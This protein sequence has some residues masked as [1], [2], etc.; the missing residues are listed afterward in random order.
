M[1]NTFYHAITRSFFGKKEMSNDSKTWIYK[2]V[3]KLILTY[4]SETVVLLGTP[5]T[6]IQAGEMNEM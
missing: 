2:R 6:K 4:A 1:S 3:I 5:R